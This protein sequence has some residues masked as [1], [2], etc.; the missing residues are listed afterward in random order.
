MFLYRFYAYNYMDSDLSATKS[1]NYEI[2][3]DNSS[4][5]IIR[6]DKKKA[7]SDDEDTDED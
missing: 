3:L 2:A 1:A 7:S 4:G 5:L 6:F